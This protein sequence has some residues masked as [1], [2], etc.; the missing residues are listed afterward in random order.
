MPGPT[1]A[2][3]YKPSDLCVTFLPFGTTHPN[4]MPSTIILI[5]SAMEY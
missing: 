3:G 1:P 4:N 5:L 2:I